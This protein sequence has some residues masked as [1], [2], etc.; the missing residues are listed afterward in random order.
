MDEVGKSNIPHLLHFACSSIALVTVRGRPPLC[1]RC[2]KVGHMRSGCPSTVTNAGTV[3]QVRQR[4]AVR[5]ADRE[6]EARAEATEKTEEKGTVNAVEDWM[7]EKT[8]VMEQVDV[9]GVEETEGMEF[10]VRGEKRA[11]SSP[12]AFLVRAALRRFR[13]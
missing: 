5:P 4:E 11:S 7:E 8:E 2:H 6:D 12:A 3:F 1:L 10:E 13:A 9:E